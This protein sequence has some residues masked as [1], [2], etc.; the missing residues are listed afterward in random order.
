MQFKGLTLLGNTF[1]ANRRVSGCFFFMVLV[2]EEPVFA[3]GHDGSV[4]TCLTSKKQMYPGRYFVKI[5]TLEES[6][7]ILLLKGK[8][9][10]G[11]QHL[12]K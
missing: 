11:G 4:L 8:K 12:R 3:W 1:G 2:V 6:K 7:G 5:I 10:D 9:G